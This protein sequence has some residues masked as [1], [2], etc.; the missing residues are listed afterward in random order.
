MDRRTF[1]S[2]A[3]GIAALTPQRVSATTGPAASGDPPVLRGT[4]DAN[5][6]GLVPDSPHDQSRLLQSLLREAAA[7]N[8][9]LVLP[10]GRYVVADIVLPAKTRIL[11]IAGV[12]VLA[13]AG[14]SHLVAAENADFVDLRGLIFDGG[15]LPL[16][17]HVPA[18]VHLAGIGEVRID[19]CAVRGS[20]KA[21]LGLD[22]SAGRVERTTVTAAAEAGIRAIE[23]AG[24]TLAANTIADCGAGIVVWRW[25]AGEDGTMV[26]GNRI[27]RIGAGAPLTGEAGDGIS[28][29][30]AH[31]V[32]IA[33]N[34]IADCA[35]AAIRAVEADGIQ[36]TGNACRGAG[37]GPIVIADDTADAVVAD[38]AVRRDAATGPVKV[39][40]AGIANSE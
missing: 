21:G 20:G 29:F 23:S 33:G 27:E 3:I 31:G 14:G 6:R 2:G 26:T 36:A 8:R 22:R 32:M 25:R 28:V 11:G 24:L 4:I 34:R 35:G 15:G 39:V 17:D 40:K 18:L 19:D 12:T 13:F 37:E 10:P 7:E 30:R 1:V 16:A 38:N 5:H 9:P